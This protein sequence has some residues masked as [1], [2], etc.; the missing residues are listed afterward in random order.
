MLHFHVGLPA[1]KIIFTVSDRCKRLN[2]GYY[3]LKLKNIQL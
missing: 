2:N 3:L 1:R